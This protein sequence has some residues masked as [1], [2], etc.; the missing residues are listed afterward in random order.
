MN[1]FAYKVIDSLARRTKSFTV[2]AQDNKQNVLVSSAPSAKNQNGSTGKSVDKSA[3][4]FD[5]K[6]D[7]E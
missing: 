7:S 1:N 5:D 3:L 4:L 6:I 2:P